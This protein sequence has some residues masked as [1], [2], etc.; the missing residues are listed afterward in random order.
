ME[1]INFDLY[2][3]NLKQLL[4]NLGF[5]TSTSPIKCIS[6]AHDDKNPSM[7]IYDSYYKC[8]SCNEHGDIYDAVGLLKGISDKK[9]QFQEV[10]KILGNYSPPLNNNKKDFTVNKNAENKLRDYLSK[11]A[12]KNQDKIIEYLKKRKCPEKM[13]NELV[14]CFGFWPG[15]EPAEKDLDKN[16][17]FAAGIPGQNPKTKK[18][19]WGPAGVVIKLGIGFKLFYYDENNKSMKIGSKKCRT[20]PTPI[21]PSS[22]NTILLVEGEID[23]ISM[24]YA[25]YYNTVA[26]GG[27]NALTDDSIQMLLPYDYIYIIFDGDKAG[28]K[29]REI[30]KQKLLENY[31]TGNIYIVRLPEKKDPDQLIKNGKKEIIETAIH[32]AKEKT[33][34]IDQGEI[35]PFIFAGYDA[36]N[37][38]IIPQNQHIT[39]GIGRSDSQIKGMMYDFAPFEFWH[40][41]FKDDK[42]SSLAWFRAESQKKGLY[43][44]EKILGLGAHFDNNNIIINIGDGLYMK[45]ENKKIDY[46][47]Y[48]GKNFYQRSFLKFDLSG[49]PWTIKETHELFN[50]L[51]NYGFE[52]TIDYMLL[53]GYLALA[54]FASL[55]F[56]RPHLAIIGPKGCGK[57]T[58]IQNIIRPAIGEL[59]IF[60]EGKTSEAGIRQRIGKDCR[61][62]VIDEFEAHNSEEILRNK[63][64]LSLARS[65]YGGEGEIIKGTIGQKPIIFKTKIMFLFS[66]INIVLDNDADRTRIPILK[67][68][69]F[70]KKIGKIFDFSGLRKRTFN[71]IKE[72]INNIE[73]AKRYIIENV[74]ADARTGDT[75]GTL[76]GGFWSVISDNS[77]LQSK[78]EIIN[79]SLI[80][81]IQDIESKNETLSDELLLFDAI[82]NHK[83]RI[84]SYTEKTITEMLTETSSEISS[85]LQHDNRLRQIGIRKDDNLQIE[86]KKYNAIAISV[87]NQYINDI[88]RNTPFFRYKNILIRHEAV[89]FDDAKPIRMI[90]NKKE[91]CIILDWQRIKEIHFDDNKD[92]PF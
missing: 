90:A 34:K 50:E 48:S 68:K 29:N 14:N 77:F 47:E 67:M 70:D 7:L 58:L 83:I 19:S 91:R 17:L 64:I 24:I 6:P 9:E 31:Y 65:A 49:T 23:A 74:I 16:T 43:N 35:L 27:V 79:N 85:Q 66:G 32:D 84:D 86:N 39:I 4:N 89:I 44:E 62:T 60:V 1:K 33:E 45:N 55:L 53:L 12:E 15:H 80:D 41:K 81:N 11:Q 69:K 46:S 25:E 5:D 52:K 51:L 26:I 61:P 63:N 30:L 8:Q 78:S 76:L 82:L 37:Y 56:R 92:L 22:D 71:N 3:N 10:A 36:K 87:N 88:L 72:V 28:R 75:Y 2:K 59:G 38:Y 13:Q 20:F 42:K 18:Y 54:P 40:A 21:L 57:T 73:L